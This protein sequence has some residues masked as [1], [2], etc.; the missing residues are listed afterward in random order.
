M[1]PKETKLQGV[2]KNGTQ[3]QQI[4]YFLKCLVDGRREN[5]HTKVFSNYIKK[6]GKY[7]CMSLCI[8]TMEYGVDS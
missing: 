3:A 6:F 8:T 5:T 4:F 1:I 7:F 2:L